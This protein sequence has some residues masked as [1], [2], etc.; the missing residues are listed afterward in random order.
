[1]ELKLGGREKQCF[2]VVSSAELVVVGLQQGLG[3][4]PLFTA[5]QVL[6]RALLLWL[7]TAATA[8]AAAWQIGVVLGWRGQGWSVL[9]VQAQPGLLEPPTHPEAGPTHWLSP[10]CLGLLLEEGADLLEGGS[11]GG[12]QGPAGLHDAVSDGTGTAY[13]SGDRDTAVRGKRAHTHTPHLAVLPSR[14]PET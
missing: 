14:G 6:A 13:G 9:M 11:S 5:G 3:N 4:I 10:V 7:T 12:L 8:T 2:P 1:M